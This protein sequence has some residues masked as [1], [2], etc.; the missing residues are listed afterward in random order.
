M[1]AFK[2]TYS[3]GT[4]GYRAPEVKPSALEMFIQQV[5]GDGEDM[6]KPPYDQHGPHTDVWSLG[7]TIQTMVQASKHAGDI[8][9]PRQRLFQPYSTRLTQ[10]IRVCQLRD[11]RARLRPYDLFVRTGRELREQ[12]EAFFA[13]GVRAAEGR[14]QDHGVYPDMVLFRKE[15]QRR[16]QNDMAYRE[17]YQKVNLKYLYEQR[18][19]PPRPPRRARVNDDA[20][21]SGRGKKRDREESREV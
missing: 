6:D 17:A 14:G 21:P 11:G 7:A 12:R 1:R 8:K 15:D 16:F 9:R 3:Y 5:Q 13:A 20:G 4:P 2:S 10:L 19:P 18:P